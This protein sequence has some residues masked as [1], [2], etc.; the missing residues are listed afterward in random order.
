MDFHG[1]L[2]WPQDKQLDN[3]NIGFKFSSGHAVETMK[4]TCNFNCYH[5]YET[6]YNEDKLDQSGD[7]PFRFLTL[8]NFK[9]D[10]VKDCPS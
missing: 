1:T 2:K 9:N 5:E 10:H 7:L 6:H 4:L 3:P 8:K